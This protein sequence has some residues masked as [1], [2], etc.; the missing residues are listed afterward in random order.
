VRSVVYDMSFLP[1]SKSTHRYSGA[2]V[3]WDVGRSAVK[4]NEIHSVIAE[5]LVASHTLCAD[6]TGGEEGALLSPVTIGS[7]VYIYGLSIRGELG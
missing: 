6:V 2:R 4:T 3:G 7:S 5:T 1:F